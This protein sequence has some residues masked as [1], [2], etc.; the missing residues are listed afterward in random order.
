MLC[1]LE[2][3]SRFVGGKVYN[4]LLVCCCCFAVLL[5]LFVCLFVCLFVLVAIGGISHACFVLGWST[6]RID[7][8]KSTFCFDRGRSAVCL[9]CW[10]KAYIT[11]KIAPV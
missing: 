3:K 9:S 10:R 7:G 2:R 4:F 1:F 11:V 8:G 5:L 6:L